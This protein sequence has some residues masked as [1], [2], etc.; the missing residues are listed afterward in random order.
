MSRK[1]FPNS[2]K[3]SP[4]QPNSW[5][6][7]RRR[8]IHL[9]NVEKNDLK[10]WKILLIYYIKT[11]LK[12]RQN[13]Q[14]T[15]SQPYFCSLSFGRHFYPLKMNQFPKLKELVDLDSKFQNLWSKWSSGPPCPPKP[16]GPLKL[17]DLLQGVLVQMIIWSSCYLCV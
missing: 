13:R 11:K 1:F 15:C 6:I 8:K 4:M 12:R 17:L 5:T 7:S 9:N 2:A 10:F 3:K 16:H 14:S